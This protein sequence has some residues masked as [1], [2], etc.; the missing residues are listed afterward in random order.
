MTELA[1]LITI[2]QHAGGFDLRVDGQE[3]P[4]YIAPSSSVQIDRGGT[5]GVTITLMAERIEVV[6]TLLAL[7]EEGEA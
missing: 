7:V 3:F 5:P 1:K 2:L 4:W 6:D